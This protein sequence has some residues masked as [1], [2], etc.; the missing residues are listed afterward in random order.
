MKRIQKTIALSLVISMFAFTACNTD[1]DT[2]VNDNDPQVD[3]SA[4]NA[5]IAAR[6]DIAVEGSFN[7]VENAY[8]EEAEGRSAE[9]S[10]FTNCA[11]VTLV[12]DGNGGT[13]TVDFGEGCTLNNGAEV[14]GQILI[15]FSPIIEGERNLTYTYEN[16][17]YNG[18]GVTGGGTILREIANT[19]GNPQSTWNGSIVVTFPDTEVTATR[20]GLRIAEWVEGVG[21]GTW[22]DNV[23][24]IEGNWTTTLSNGFERTGEVTETLVRELDCPFLVSGELSITQQ[25]LTGALNFGAGECD[26]IAIFTFNGVDYT[27]IL[28]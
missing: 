28:Q 13:I 17:T 12:T 2:V 8:A 6:T 22:E 11:I 10:L 1:D 19:D 9:N 21:S 18:N 16:F 7:I 26:N 15:E 14:S 25:S 27:I 24:H 20:N 3:F 4:D 23:Y 5:T